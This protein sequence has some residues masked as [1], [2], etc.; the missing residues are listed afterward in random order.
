M[1]LSRT[2][3]AGPAPAPGASAHSAASL[4]TDVIIHLN[5]ML[6]SRTEQVRLQ[7]A[8]TIGAIAHMGRASKS[9]ICACDGMVSKLV[10]IMNQGGLEALSAIAALIGGGECEEA[11][12]QAR[13][14]GAIGILAGCISRPHKFPH[15]GLTRYAHS[16]D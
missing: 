7:A 4:P 10:I 9:A 6:S 1:L 16:H 2:A 12:D 11:C 3:A 8:K 14:A 13:Q 15:T 5:L